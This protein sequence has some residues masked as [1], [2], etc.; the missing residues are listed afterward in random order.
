MNVYGAL[1]IRLPKRN[2]FNLSHSKRTTL[3]IGEIYPSLAIEMVP[4]D[5]FDVGQNAIVELSPLVA[6]FKGELNLDT[7]L[8]FVSYNQLKI[9][10]DAGSFSDILLSVNNPQDPVPV[11]KWE[12]PN[13]GYSKGSL[14]DCLGFPVGKTVNTSAKNVKV[15]PIDYLRRA[16]NQVWNYDFRDEQY[17]EEVS[18]QN[19]EILNVRYKKDRFTSSFDSPQ[20]GTTPSMKLSGNASV[21]WEEQD[22][23]DKVAGI[24]SNRFVIYNNNSA[25]TNMYKIPKGDVDLALGSIGTS[26]TNVPSD[27]PVTFLGN[28]DYTEGDPRLVQGTT[29]APIGSGGDSQAYSVPLHIQNKDGVM[30]GTSKYLAFLDAAPGTSYNQNLRLGVKFDQEFIN[31][32][33]DNNIDLDSVITFNIEDLRLL[34]KLQLWLEKNQ[35][36]GTRYKEYLLANYGVAPSDETLQEP[37]YIGGVHI[38]VIISPVV[39]KSGTDDQP[40]GTV[41][42]RGVTMDKSYLGKYRAKEFGILMAFSVLR[43]KAAYSQGIDRQFIKNSVWDFFN[44]TFQT[45]GQEEILGAEIFVEGD[46]DDLDIIGYTGRYNEMR[47]M[48][49][50]VTGELRDSLSVWTVQRQFSNRPNLQS[51]EFLEVDKS[52]YDYLFSVTDEPQAVVSFKNVVKAVRP[53]SKFPIATLGA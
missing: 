50:L 30:F 28:I 29:R 43:P 32:L 15:A 18:L 23:L 44:P 13:G 24:V 52:D 11:P 26:R 16:Y 22:L 21:K 40:L 10:D 2:A 49:D 31:L 12:T 1:P 36:Y 9:D 51:P 53:L 3:N 35:L 4:G 7:Y 45:L 38:P 46:E 42:G 8:F 5:L 6:D 20:R 17:D 25:G 33:N 48:T 19:D 27:I 34:N 47:A 39:S 41:G 37:A 14:W